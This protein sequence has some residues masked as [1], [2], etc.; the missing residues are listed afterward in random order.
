M[1]FLF[2]Q[3]FCSKQLQIMLACCVLPSHCALN[4]SNDADFCCALLAPS[5]SA[6][7]TSEK[8]NGLET[9]TNYNNNGC[10]KTQC[11]M[12]FL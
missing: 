10:W 9:T 8:S 5:A 1:Y 7:A 4:N 12:N 3:T 11:A 6:S 2:D